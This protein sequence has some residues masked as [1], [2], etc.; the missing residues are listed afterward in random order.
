MLKSIYLLLLLLLIAPTAVFS[1]KSYDGIILGTIIDAETQS[2]VEDAVIEIL[3][4]GNKT[5]TDSTG[6][7]FFQNLKY[8]SYQIKISGTGYD[9]L[10]K[11]DLIVYAS[12]PLELIIKMNSKGIIT[13]QIDVE[14][15][16]FQK[17]SDVNIS[18]LNLDFEEIRRAP[19]ATEDISRMI[20]TIPGVSIGN[21][22]RNDIIVRGGSPAENLILI[23]GI[24]IPNINHFGTDG[25]TSGA[26]GFI[27]VKFIQETGILTGGFPTTFGDKLSSVIDISFR[28]GSK[29]KFY[30]DI[31]LSI[32]GFGGIFEGP[33]SEK[34]SYLFSV[35]RSY[36]ELIKNSIRLTSV[37]NYWDF[38]LKADYEISPK[39]KITLIG[40]LGLD[41][42]DFSE[43]SAE[44][45]PYG[46]SQDDQKT[47]A[48]GINYK[49][50]FKKG[51]IQT[52]LS[53]SYTDNYI[54]QID[55][56]SALIK[57]ENKA[58][59]NE[60]I[61]KSD[62]NY[63]LSSNLS[64]NTGIGGKYAGIKNYLFLKGDT[65]AAGFVFDTIN[66]DS[67]FN[68]V[69]LF[70]H[71]N[72]TSK[73]LKDRLVVNTGVRLDYF[74]YIRLKT[75]FSPRI[76]ASYKITP[77]TSLNAA[78]GIYYQSPEYIWLS[79]HPD[80]KNLNSIRS[81][82]YILGLDHFFSGDLKATVELFYKNY[83][84]YP[85]WKDIPTYILID[86]G[87]EFGPNIVGEAVSAGTG[88]VKGIDVSLQKKLSSQKGLYGI[89]N[90]SYI[91]TGFTALAGGEKPG[92]FDPG[93]QFTLIAGYQFSSGWLAGLKF[94]YSGGRPYTPLDYDA[95]KRV[96]REV[97]ATDD[98]NSSRYPYYMRIDMR[99]DK[100]FDFSKASLVCYIELQ[101]LFDRE[102]IYS[103]YWNEDN[104]KPGTIYQ[105]A[106]FPVGGISIQF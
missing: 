93:H 86:G 104:K 91:N 54:V 105:W 82:H 88:Y 41:K 67:K 48:A 34:G 78:A 45:N 4:T 33:L 29:K 70:G 50:L 22:Q 28:E 25:S 2:P 73:F 6:N 90:Y 35:R 14:A 64:L 49:K 23:D 27:N 99:V 80:N 84:D 75:Y 38:N 79:S 9:P 101:N 13:D 65:N 59:N 81:D 46:N 97:Y 26:I 42:I 19:G 106:F 3:N 71:A 103:Y 57:F 53:D 95:S 83:K 60:I 58:N 56:Q 36:L 16:Y 52:V 47:F 62:L 87:T 96:N 8:D 32:A 37:P 7:F 94:K 43:E 100:K 51:F 31:N 24:E 85:V 5:T 21:D 77:V 63:Q 72:L 92:A 18:S 55:G 17:S 102:N 44:N 1:Q 40:L 74:D 12:K 39:D 66:A 61:L 11:S 98:F 68:A 30:S 89:I 69:K 15:N 20:Q 10:I 76:G